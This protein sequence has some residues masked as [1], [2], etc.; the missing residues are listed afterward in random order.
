ML[1]QTGAVIWFTGLSGSGKTTLALALER[2]LLEAG[3]M[4]FTLDGDNLRHGLCRD[5]GFGARDRQENIRRA[6]AVAGLLADAGLICVTAF[7]SPSRAMREQARQL[8]GPQ[9]FL[10]VHVATPLEVCERRDCK[11]LY[12]RARA[13]EVAEFTGISAP[14]EAPEQPALTL[15]TSRTELPEALARLLQLVKPFLGESAAK[16]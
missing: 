2:A 9:R 5:L 3:Y 6:A 8:I 11:G 13:G 14:Y 7:I 4:A 16:P 10:E 1:G 15:D 12:A